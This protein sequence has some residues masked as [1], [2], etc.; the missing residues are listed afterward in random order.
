MRNNSSETDFFETIWANS[1][2]GFKGSGTF[3][4][5]KSSFLSSRFISFSSFSLFTL[6]SSLVLSY[7]LLHILSVCL[8]LRV[9]LC[10]SLWLWCVCVCVR[11]DTLKTPPCVHSKRPRVY[12]QNVSMCIGTTRTCV[13]Y[14]YDLPQWF[15]L[16]CFSLLFQALFQL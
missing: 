12:V 16:F 7:L 6:L 1:S 4:S 3:F 13:V 10:V 2:C 15:H 14:V 5:K 8:C 9:M 11:C